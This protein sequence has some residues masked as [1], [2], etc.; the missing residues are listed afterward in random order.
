MSSVVDFMI[1]P[2]LKSQVFT[3]T[4]SQSVFTLTTITIPD[5]DQEKSILIINGKEQPYSSY[6]VDSSTQITVS[7]GVEL[8]DHVELKIVSY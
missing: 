2:K 3:A 5:A 4:A 1:K 7:G 8:D 6:T